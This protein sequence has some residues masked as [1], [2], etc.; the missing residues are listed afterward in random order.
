M[1]LLPQALLARN[2]KVMPNTP[3]FNPA[4]GFV[5]L[6]VGI[7]EIEMSPGAFRT[8]TE[9][10][11][12]ADAGGYC[13]PSLEQ[14]SARLSRSRA[15]ISGYVK[16]LKETGLI[17]TIQQRMAN[18]YNYRL[19]FHVTFWAEWRRSL[20][21]RQ[22]ARAMPVS[23][24]PDQ[25]ERSVQQTECRVNS[26]NQIHENHGPA[27]AG[28]DVVVSDILR[29]WARLTRGV[30]FGSYAAPVPQ[31]VIETS[32]LIVSQR[33]ATEPSLISAD[34]EATLA[35]LWK[36]LHVRINAADLQQQAQKLQAAS[37]CATLLRDFISA[38][39]ANWKPHWRRPPS[40]K[41]FDALLQDAK[42]MSPG[43]AKRELVRRYL[44]QW[45][46]QQNDLQN[47][48]WSSNLA[49]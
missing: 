36:G 8:L 48:S 42:Q 27:H 34:I 41:Q 13:W 22:P 24:T 43:K 17:E 23:E 20:K 6:P 32:R 49:A 28:A 29:E 46:R 37:C 40:P 44:Y 38:V 15:A 2:R 31:R 3:Q 47:G 11:R 4:N 33:E 1:P 21:G 25:S 35:R 19:K 18:G 16:E 10:C 30:P 5:A 14:L 26:K 7:L 12:M 39:R 9:L 45:E